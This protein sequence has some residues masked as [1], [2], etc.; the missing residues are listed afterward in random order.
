MVIIDAAKQIMMALRSRKNL[1]DDEKEILGDLHTQLTTAIAISEKEVD[2]INKIE[3]RLNVIQ[4][5]IMCWERYWPMIWDSG[6]DEATEYLNAADE[7]RQVTK[8]LEILCLTEDRKKEMLQRARNLLQI[9]M[10]RLQEEFKHMLTKNRQPFEPKHVPAVSIAVNA[11]SKIS[12]GNKLVRHSMLRKIINRNAEEFTINLVQYDVIPELRRI[13]NVMSIS[14]YANECSLAYISI[15]RSALDECLRILE[16]EKL[17]TEDVLK[18][19]QIFGE[20]GT[21]NLVS[22]TVPLVLQLLTYFGEVISTGP[23]NPGKLFHLLDMYEVL[24]GLLPYLDSLYSDKVIS[25]VI[26]DGDMVLRGLADSV[27]KTLDEF[28]DSIMTYTM[29]E[30]FAAEGIHPLTKNVM[31][32]IIALTG[33]HETLDFL[34]SDHCGEHPMPAPSCMS[35]GVE[36]E[37]SSGGTCDFSPIARHFLSNDSIL[38]WL[39]NGSSMSPSTKE[40]HISGGTCKQSPLALHFRAFSCILENKLYNKAKLFKDASLEH[41][42]LMNN[43]HYMAQKIKYSELQFILGAEWIQEHDWEF[44]QHVR[45]YT[46]VTWSPVLSL[47]KDEGNTNSY[48]VSKAHV[49]EKLRSFYLAFEEVCGAQTACSIPDD[50]LREKVAV[51]GCNKEIGCAWNCEVEKLSYQS[52]IQ[53]ARLDEAYVLPLPIPIHDSAIPSLNPLHTNYFPLSHINTSPSSS[54]NI[55][56]P[57]EQCIPS[58]AEI[59]PQP[60]KKSSWVKHTPGYLHD[61][62]CHIATST[63]DP[64]SYPLSSALSYNHLSSTQ[65]SFSLSVSALVEPTSYIQAVKHEEWREAMANEIKAL[66][67]ND[68]WTIVDLPAF[69]HVIGCKWVY[70]VKLHFDGTLERYKACSSSQ[71]VDLYQLDVNNAFLHSQLNE[72]VYM[73]LPPRFSKQGE[74][75]GSF[76]ALLVYVDD[77]I[78]ASNNLARVLGFIKLLNDRFKLKDLSQLKYFLGLEVARNELGISVCQRKYAL[79]VLED[80]GM[81]ASKPVRFPMEPDVKL[82]KDS[83]QF[84]DNPTA[85]RR[86]VGQLLYPTISR[87]DISFAMQV[88]SQ[89]MDKPQVP[90]T[91]VLRYIKASV[92]F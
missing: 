57:T 3:E 10:G 15:Q 6:L 91:K 41:I 68:T 54:S 76:I 78:V 89:F 71:E 29:T 85:Y 11:I 87:P 40:D 52:M 49:E 17:R 82:S 50:Q 39:S 47:L 75:K 55:N 63:S 24:A 73:S 42:F 20:L 77:I 45:N 22:F 9:S 14:G 60:D 59:T 53:D 34:L 28:E 69:K 65:K 44:Q 83:G 36:E 35:S 56:P 32:Y 43:I 16:R 26:V 84:L 51:K 66:E 1:T 19:D 33:Y 7:A 92:M 80:T 38:K 64:L 88:L 90:A 81:L 12:L 30:P 21:V 67:Q 23:E 37:N 8:K 5:K 25:Q 70:K 4:G 48:A 31:N 79:E 72:E 62:H 27:R 46:R 18:L 86:L 13:A 2:E 58:A 74:S 61:Y